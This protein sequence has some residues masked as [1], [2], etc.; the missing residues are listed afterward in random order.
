[1][2]ASLEVPNTQVGRARSLIE[3][4]GENL[5]CDTS[6]SIGISPAQIQANLLACKE[7]QLAK[8]LNGY[9]AVHSSRVHLVPRNDSIFESEVR[10]ARASVVLELVSGVKVSSGDVGAMVA[11][12][13][14]AVDG[15]DPERVAISDTKG[16]ALTS[17][18]GSEGLS[19]YE[20][21][22]ERRLALED[23]Y[24]TRIEMQLYKITGSYAAFQVGVAV[25]LDPE[26]KVI[27]ERTVN[28]DNVI[29][30]S[31]R[32]SESESTKAAANGVPGTA[33]NDL[34]ERAAGQDDS[35]SQSEMQSTSNQD[36]GTLVTQ[37]V[38]EAGVLRSVSIGVTVSAAAVEAALAAGIDEAAFV[39]KLEA[40]IANTVPSE[41]ENTV[42]VAVL[43]YAAVEL[44]DSESAV[45]WADFAAF[46]PSAVA[47]V[48]IALVF[49]TVVR[50][51]MAKVNEFKTPEQVQMDDAEA[52]AEAEAAA[53]AEEAALADKLRDLV[54]N[55]EHVDAEDLNR[56]VL[57]KAD[58]AAEVLRQWSRTA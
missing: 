39:E 29:I 11:T 40:V 28:P 33:N 43:P 56:L 10:P 25:D 50:P 22:D 49:G 37:T 18:R 7:R 15:L 9:D 32:I 38:V 1:D 54:D 26:S 27:N 36:Y 17:G 23:E 2:G 14:N 46:G 30:V 31:E 53:A 51:L 42:E 8:T 5:D 3:S 35:Q 45:V 48:A 55:F 24:R 6:S 57:G 21:L 12:V 44:M 19:H 47:L 41:I 4:S 34:P 13:A 16:N 20:T 52:E 58:A